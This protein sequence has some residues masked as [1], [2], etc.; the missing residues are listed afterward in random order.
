VLAAL[1]AAGVFA[2]AAQ[3]RV[4]TPV[5]IGSNAAAATAS[6]SLSLTTSQ[7]VPA[8]ATIVLIAHDNLAGSGVAPSGVSCSDSAGNI[9]PLALAQG[10][11]D[12]FDSVCS[13]SASSALPSGS[14]ITISWSGGSNP[15][16]EL[17]EAFSVAGVTASP[18]EQT[19]AAT[20]TSTTPSTPATSTTA[21]AKELLFAAIADFGQSVSSA[22]FTPGT[23]G[24]TN[25]CTA[26]GTST[27]S[28]LGG[29]DESGQAPS[30]FGMYCV[31]SATGSYSASAT[32]SASA[33]WAA[34]LATYELAVTT[35]STAVGPSQN[36]SAPGQSVTFTATVTG[37]V[38][39][40][41]VVFK[42]GTATILGCGAQP[43]TGGV[44]TC[45]TSGLSTGSHT[46]TAAYGGDD[47]D[48]ASTSS[49]LTQ[50]VA[51]A[52]SASISAPASGA[53]YAVGQVVDSSF[54]CADGA[55]GTG[56]ASCLDQNGDPSGTAIDTSTTGQHTFTVT[57][58]SKDGLIGTA[59][60]T[61]TVAGAPSV[62]ITSPDDGQTF[63]VEQVV[64]TSF[65]CAEGTSG[66]GLSSCTD[67]N[68]ADAPAGVLDTSKT[69]TFT[70]TV[71]ATSKNG[72]RV[73]A[74]IHYTVAGAPSV[75]VSSPVDGA[76]YTRGDIV[77][78]GYE[79]RD[80]VSG[81]GIGSCSGPVASGA[82]VDTSQPGEHTFTVTAISI[83]GQRTAVTVH[84]TIALP[85]N[86]FTVR[87]LRVRRNGTIE[88]DVAVPNAGQLDVLETAWKNN[89]A[90]AATRLQPAERRFVLARAHKNAR[91][92]GT[93]HFR[94]RP[95]A[96]GKL[97]VKH[98]TYGVT[99]RLWVTYT[100]AGGSYRKQG[101]YG[102]HLPKRLNHARAL[103]HSDQLPPDEAS[104][105]DN[106]S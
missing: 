104:V 12:H 76:V 55:G 16:D 71:T 1:A 45:T 83:D 101:F 97:L 15:Q 50:T 87:H 48:T 106:R 94:V 62:Q 4:V 67:S 57:A 103:P 99:L 70:Y 40:G 72:Q 7:A 32:V 26:T 77:A 3:A 19:A 51:S 93:L 85:S 100:P 49:P 37:D 56:I 58:T 29:I 61:Y 68:G 63:A 79:C 95:N 69:G 43:L 82:A 89:L 17:I 30:L 28:S 6:T 64:P 8:G 91:R 22:G 52:P 74:S 42:D 102:L 10:G 14:T 86:H 34:M 9:Y 92:G 5:S 105:A 11:T 2:A 20:G 35:S 88:F 75:Q 53:T 80:G 24:T 36:P 47:T 31:V 59:S 38:P 18:L 84:Y 96:R 46:I 33:E 23:N 25:R 13:L 44:A 78:A 66:P 21:Q 73:R 39:T 98:H 41:T 60:V 65:S 54:T 81:P 90:H 27:Y